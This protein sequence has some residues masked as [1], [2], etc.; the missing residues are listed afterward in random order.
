[1]AKSSCVRARIGHNEYW[2]KR[3]LGLRAKA[4]K[5]SRPPFAETGGE[6]DRLTRFW[7]VPVRTTAITSQ[8]NK[9]ITPRP[10][11]KI[12]DANAIHNP[13][14]LFF[15][16]VV[17]FENACPQARHRARCHAPLAS[18]Q[19]AALERLRSPQI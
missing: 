11:R 8:P 13:C 10:I 17:A 18:W 6:D 7:A 15:N 16:C 12:T 14:S 4:A 2:N 19:S 1:M 5:A 3:A 9:I